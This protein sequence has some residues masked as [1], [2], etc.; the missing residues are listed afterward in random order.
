MNAR[1]N[2]LRAVRFEKPDYIPLSIWINPSCFEVYGHEQIF[3]LMESHPLLYPDFKRPQKYIPE[4]AP[5]ARKDEPFTDDF[6][7]LLK[8]SINGITGT[9]V[10]HP[11]A[12]WNKFAEWKKRIPDPEYRMGIGPADWN[13]KKI[14]I[15]DKKKRGELIFTGLRHGHTFL[16]LCDLRGYQNLLYDFTDKE[17][18]IFE[19]IDILE[20]FNRATAEHYLKIG[21]DVFG[22]PDDLGMQNGPMISPADFRNFIK[23]VY[24]RLMK[25]FR[26]KGVPVHMHSDGDIRSLIDDL[27]E[28][29]VEIINLQDLVNG[30]DFIKQRLTGKIC[31]ELDIDRQNI[32]V[33]GTPKEID[34]HIRTAVSTLGS[35]EGGLML[36]YGC[37]PGTPVKNAK[38]VMDAMEKYSHFYL[39]A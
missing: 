5:N 15:D 6:G 24:K 10:D 21:T 11:L 36:V 22:F 19:L 12:D 31:V 26:E 8:T 7:C 3:D 1:E 33:F 32:T 23:P 37:Y 14:E 30:I 13:N 28:D 25:P 35:R 9:A 18:N 20:N 38:A 34:D 17:K 2:Y 29:G 4:F 16:Q 27:I 39:T